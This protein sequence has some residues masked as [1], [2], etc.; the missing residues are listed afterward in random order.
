MSLILNSATLVT[1]QVAMLIDTLSNFLPWI[2]LVT[3]QVAMLIDTLSHFLPW[4]AL[5]TSQVAMLID[6]LS[7]FLPWIATK[8]KIITDRRQLV[9]LVRCAFS[10]RNLH[11]MMP[12]VP[13]PARLKLLHAC[14]Q[15]H[16]FRVFT[17]LTVSDCEI[18]SKH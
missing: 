6:T 11:S 2:A 8:L 17:P 3:S 14:V 13:T 1:S 12:L 15:W 18:T 7:H 9:V 16:S 4:I 5:V 10:D